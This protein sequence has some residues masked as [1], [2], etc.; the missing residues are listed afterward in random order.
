[1][2]RLVNRLP[3]EPQT[4]LAFV[5]VAL[6]TLVVAQQVAQVAEVYRLAAELT[7]QQLAPRPVRVPAF[8]VN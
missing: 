7:R 4:P 3:A 2:N 6:P 5:V 1:M 8:S